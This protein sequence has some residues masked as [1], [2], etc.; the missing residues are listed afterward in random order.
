MAVVITSA[1]QG[2]LTHIR[3]PPERNA[4]HRMISII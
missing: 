4:Y 1:V 2:A 3:T